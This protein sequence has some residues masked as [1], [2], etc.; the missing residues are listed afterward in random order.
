L[1]TQRREPALLMQHRHQIALHVGQFALGDPDLVAALARHD[2]PRRTFR[3]LVEADQAR[4][5]PPHRPHEEIMQS[6]VDQPRG[7]HRDEERDHHDVAGEPVHRLAQRQLVGDHLDEL[8][9][10]RRR[11]DHADGLVAG[12]Q[13]HLE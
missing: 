8:R 2:D 11:A 6:K 13:H 3:I 7:Q 12:L 5:E 1:E 10:A 4:G 9:A